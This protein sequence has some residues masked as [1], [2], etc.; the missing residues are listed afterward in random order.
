MKTQD[1]SLCSTSIHWI[2]VYV[3]VYS[4]I[5]YLLLSRSVQVNKS[6]VSKEK[7]FWEALAPC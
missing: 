6:C 2:D 5:Y 1:N 3:Y 7:R 4:E